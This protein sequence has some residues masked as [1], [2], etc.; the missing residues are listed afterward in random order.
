M[1]YDL[2]QNRIN[3]IILNH[4]QLQFKFFQNQNNNSKQNINNF[5]KFNQKTFH[6]LDRNNNYISENNQKPINLKNNM[7]SFFNNKINNNNKNNI[8][9]N[10]QINNFQFNNNEQKRYLNSRTYDGKKINNNDKNFRNNSKKNMNAQMNF[11]FKNININDKNKANETFDEKKNEMNKATYLS[12]ILKNKDNNEPYQFE[13]KKEDKIQNKINNNEV[14]KQKEYK[15]KKHIPTLENSIFC[16]VRKKSDIID[17]NETNAI[18]SIIQLFYSTYSKN[19]KKSL[20]TLVSENI[21][22]KL[23]GEWFVF[24][25]RKDVKI[26]LNFTNISESDFLIIDI[27]KTQFKI[28]KTK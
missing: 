1:N 19:K 26:F 5:I 21:K 13:E 24:V 12:K 20:S 7:N 25:S 10:N 23:G 28:I 4:K 9:N 8:F 27:G 16:N 17:I 22:K 14:K 2:N 6:R 11:S 18:A 15:P 3:N